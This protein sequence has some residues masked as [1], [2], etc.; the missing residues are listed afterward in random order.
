MSALRTGNHI[1][2]PLQILA[3]LNH[4]PWVGFI[5]KPAASVYFRKTSLF[6]F[7]GQEHGHV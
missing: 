3:K 1:G 5:D 2:L 4:Y 6:S 7:R